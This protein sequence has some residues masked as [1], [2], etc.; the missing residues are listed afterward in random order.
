MSDFTSLQSQTTALM[1]RQLQRSRR[2]PRVRTR[3]EER[4]LLAAY[5][6]L[7]REPQGQIILDHLAERLLMF[8]DG[9]HD[10]GARRLVLTIFERI[11][12]A[13]Q[14]LQEDGFHVGR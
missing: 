6:W 10:E 12:T 9:P 14:L 7:A 11:A 4:G 2:H 5:L 1:Q 13:Q 3:E 8:C